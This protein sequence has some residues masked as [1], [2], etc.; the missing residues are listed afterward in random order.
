MYNSVFISKTTCAIYNFPEHSLYSVKSQRCN[1]Q[2]AHA[3]V[4][5]LFVSQELFVSFAMSHIIYLYHIIQKLKHTLANNTTFMFVRCNFRKCHNLL[6][7]LRQQINW[8]IVYMCVSRWKT[9]FG[10]IDGC[11]FIRNCCSFH[12][13]WIW[14]LC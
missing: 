4:A 12:M 6:C 13:I 9:L 7:L 3:S 11:E 14:I 2:M 8:G 10:R 1:V 5:R